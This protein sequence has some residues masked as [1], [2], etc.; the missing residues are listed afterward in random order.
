MNAEDYLERLNG[1]LK[2]FSEEEKEEIMDELASHIE[3]GEEDPRLGDRQDREG[4]VMSEM[5]DPADLARSL[6]HLNR[7][8]RWEDL[9]WVIVPYYLLNEA[10][11][12]VL[13]ATIYRQPVSPDPSNPFF[14]LTSRVLL[15]AWLVLI[16]VGW[17]RRSAV[18]MIF[19]TTEAINTLAM[20]VTREQRWI[21]GNQLIGT[22]WGSFLMV[23]GLAVLLIWLVHVLR[24]YHFDLLLAVFAL[25][26]LASTAANWGTMQQ[27]VTL[28]IAQDPTSMLILSIIVRIVWV[29]SIAAFFLL[30]PRESR[31]FSLVLLAAN[32]SIPNLVMYSGMAGVVA[33]WAGVF[34][35]VLAGWA[36]DASRRRPDHRLVE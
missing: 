5:G 6:R 30:R 13:N 16:W 15:L 32:Q 36:L 18:L 19:W 4:K 8:G 33:M 25:F 23:A 14:Y 3:S 27:T 20:L 1:Q 26:P 12:L 17:K 10:V 29:G 9:L 22:V 28:S 21:P 34:G 7:P 11:V 31:W 2:W 24:R 35:L